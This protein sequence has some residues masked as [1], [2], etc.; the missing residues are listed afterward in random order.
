MKL[1][2]CPFCGGEAEVWHNNV[3]EYKLYTAQCMNCG[4]STPY[5]LHEEVAIVAWSRRN[6][7]DKVVEQLSEASYLVTD[8]EYEEYEVVDV[9]EA[10][11]IVKGGAV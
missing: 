4:V 1:K 3:E 11:E 5:Y 9:D 2:P 8:F 10:I 7:I 6:P